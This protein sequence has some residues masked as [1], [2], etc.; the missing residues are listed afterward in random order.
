MDFSCKMRHTC[1]ALMVTKLQNK[2]IPSISEKNN[3]K[4]YL[5]IN[6]SFKITKENKLNTT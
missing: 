4:Y 6:K 1:K 5:K 2:N 3:I